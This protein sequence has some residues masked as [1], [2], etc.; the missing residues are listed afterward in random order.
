MRWQKGAVEN[1][2][3]RTRRFLPQSTDPPSITPAPLADVT[4][5]MTDAP[6]KRLGFQTPVEAFRAA[7]SEGERTMRR[8][9]SSLSHLGQNPRGRRSSRRRRDRPETANGDAVCKRR[10]HRPEAP[11]LAPRSPLWLRSSR[12]ARLGFRPAF[13]GGQRGQVR[14][15]H[16]GGGSHRRHGGIKARERSCTIHAPARA[17]PPRTPSVRASAPRCTRCV[18][19]PPRS[20]VRV[21]L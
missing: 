13:D 3:R 21:T 5:R 2:N 4:T 11:S 20:G 15:T 12:A 17:S 10:V 18:R 6:R 16:A 19:C 7:V 14:E 9:A 1:T 8:A